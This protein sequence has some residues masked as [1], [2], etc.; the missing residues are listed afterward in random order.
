MRE[1]T[2]LKPQQPKAPVFEPSPEYRAREKRFNDAVRLKKPDRVPIATI[3]ASFMNRYAGVTDAES[4]YDYERTAE[5]WKYTTSKFNFDMTSAP[6][7]KFPGRVMELLGIKT[8]KWP[9][10]NLNEN[11]NYQF[12]EKEYMLADEYDELLNDPS[13]FVIRKMMPRMAE[14]LE[15]LGMLTPLHWFSSGYSLLTVFPTFAGM[16]PMA[17]MLQKLVRIGE[18]MNKYNTFQSKLTTDLAVMGYPIANGVMALASFDWISDMFR[19]L[20]GTSLDMFRVPDKLKAA[21]DLFTPMCIQS[22]IMVAKM[23]GNPRV[24][25]LLHRGAGGFMSNEQFAEFY[26]P[27]LKKMILAL[28][29]AG[30]TPM[31]FFEGD[32]TP[33]LEFLAE[34]PPGKVLGHFDVVDKKKAKE[35]IGDVMC[36]WGNVPPGLLIAGTPQAIKDYVRE[37]ID[38]FGDNGGLIVDGAVDGIPPESKPENVEAMVEAVFEYG[39]Y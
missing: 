15:P 31:P 17:E 13:D 30:L 4:L 12:V 7:V 39:V 9:G 8:F 19:G 36:F 21:I 28:I 29:D 37:L 22:S 23:I 35:I 11:L 27:S 14:A 2:T 6:S 18:E 16:P 20:R 5:A 1:E 33:R 34:L 26:W 3:A 38:I 25:I 32:Y 10:Y 24:C